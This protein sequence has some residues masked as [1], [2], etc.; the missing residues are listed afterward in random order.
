MNID[1][2]Y[3]NKVNQRRNG[4]PT[5]TLSSIM[6]QTDKKASALHLRLTTNKWVQDF[7]NLTRA[8]LGVLYY[9]ETSDPFGDRGVQVTVTEMAKELGLD[10]SNVNKDYK[11][12]KDG[13]AE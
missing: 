10:K 4:E 1:L 12:Y 13:T 9:V 7:R 11:D 3:V 8:Q 5:T 2:L 6:T